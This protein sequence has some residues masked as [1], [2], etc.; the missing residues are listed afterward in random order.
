M[1]FGALDLAVL[2]ATEPALFTA[3]RWPGVVTLLGIVVVACARPRDRRIP[4]RGW[5]GSADRFAD[6]RLGRSARNEL[7]R[8]EREDFTN[9]IPF[10][11]RH[12][13]K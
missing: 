12:Q 8:C 6:F 10:S 1:T 11:G 5:S 4:A 13:T 9:R 3:F 2:L 7:S